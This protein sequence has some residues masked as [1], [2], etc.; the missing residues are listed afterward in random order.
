MYVYIRIYMYM[1]ICMAF[2]EQAVV[3]H[4]MP[5]IDTV[6][7]YPEWYDSPFVVI[8]QFYRHLRRSSSNSKDGIGKLF[9]ETTC[10]TS[11]KFD[12]WLRQQTLRRPKSQSLD[13]LQKSR[14]PQKKDFVLQFIQN[15]SK[16]S[17]DQAHIV[18]STS[19][20]PPQHNERSAWPIVA[21]RDD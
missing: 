6:D 13:I 2:V 5:I 7:S 1:Y 9:I 20:Y 11:T 21:Y 12:D 16:S 3:R 8:G 18:R 10:W 4:S 19:K 14:L 15:L 17:G